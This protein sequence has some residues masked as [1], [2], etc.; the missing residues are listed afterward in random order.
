METY[1]T[2]E[3]ALQNPT[4]NET[5]NVDNELKQFVVNFVGEHLQ[6]EDG[7]VTVEMVIEVL[8]TH[9]PEATFALAE[10]NFMRGYEQALTDR[11]SLWEESAPAEAPWSPYAGS[12]M[13]KEDY[14]RWKKT[15]T[16][17]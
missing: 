10:E 12:E 5:V 6:P 8:A 9:F 7:N 3:E 4:L 11:D 2:V 17:E 1:K 14:L 15:Q 16:D 13:D